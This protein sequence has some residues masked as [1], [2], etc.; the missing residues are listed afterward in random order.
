MILSVTEQA[1]IQK[2]TKRDKSLFQPDIDHSHK[3]LQ[4]KIQG[5]RILVIGAG[6]SI[7]SEFVL[8][9]I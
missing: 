2:I 3:N 5:S 4:E 8:R 1:I 9:L 7:G 6:G